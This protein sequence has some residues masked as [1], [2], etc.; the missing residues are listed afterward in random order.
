MPI[1]AIPH[2]LEQLHDR[3]RMSGDTGGAIRVRAAKRKFRILKRENNIPVLGWCEYCNAEFA[4]DPETIGQPKDAHAHIQKQFIAHKC[5]RPGVGKNTV[6][7]V[8][9]TAPESH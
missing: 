8:S 3:Q 2:E 5:K 9:E 4:A 1:E 6:R 7:I